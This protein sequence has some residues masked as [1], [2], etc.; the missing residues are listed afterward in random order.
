[1]IVLGVLAGLVALCL[2]GISRIKSKVVHERG[3]FALSFVPWVHLLVSYTIAFYVRVGFGSW[4]RSC[5][6]NPA[7]P[8]LDGLVMGIVIGLLIIP[9]GI[10][11]WLGWFIIR[12]RR[13]MNCYRISSSAVFITGIILMVAAQ[14][15]DP[16]KFWNWVWD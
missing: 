2:F 6:D 16:W 13:K 10:P 15:A 7:L 4:P 8:M 14:V 9:L 3:H 1:M 5:I 11:V 12:I